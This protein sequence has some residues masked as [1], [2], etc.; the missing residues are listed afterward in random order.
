MKGPVAPLVVLPALGA[1][2]WVSRHQPVYRQSAQVLAVA[3]LVVAP[4]VL[5]L[6]LRGYLLQLVQ[7]F[8]GHEVLSRAVDQWKI[9][10]PWW[11][12]LVYL[13]LAT[14]PWSGLLLL[15]L[16]GKAAGRWPGAGEPATFV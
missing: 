13:W 8:L 6:A 11:M 9:S 5:A 14:L 16:D 7:Q 10:E 2:L 4:W 12:L 15:G 3:G 1:R